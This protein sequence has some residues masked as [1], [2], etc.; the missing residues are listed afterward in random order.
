MKFSNFSRV[1]AVPNI[2]FCG[3]IDILRSKMEVCLPLAY[4]NTIYTHFS[5]LKPLA[6]LILLTKVSKAVV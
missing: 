2:K 3:Q 1:P 4:P 6:G 5:S